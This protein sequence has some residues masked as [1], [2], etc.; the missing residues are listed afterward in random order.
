ML[1][2]QH[3]SRSTAPIDTQLDFATEIDSDRDS[4]IFTLHPPLGDFFFL[5]ALINTPENLKS[6]AN[7]LSCPLE[8]I[9]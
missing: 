2:L 7:K 1:W 6:K 4:F 5:F 3:P 9:L 8:E